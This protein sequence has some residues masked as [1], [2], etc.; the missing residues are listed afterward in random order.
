MPAM[1]ALPRLAPLP[2]GAALTACVPCSTSP[3]MAGATRHEITVAAD[4]SVATP[5]DLEAERVAVAFGGFASCLYVVD[6][7]VP[8]VRDALQMNARRSVPRMKRAVRG[9]WRAVP[10]VAE[11]CCRA[12]P[13]AA[14]AA[15]HLRSPEHVAI[16]AG[17]NPSLTTAVLQ[18]VL[19]AHARAGSFDLGLDEWA[20][21]RRCVL[22]P[23]GPVQLW[24]A[25]MHPRVVAAI[26]A[27]VVGDEGPALPEALY[28]G[29]LSR[30]PDLGWMADTL[31]AAASAVS[32]PISR[33]DTPHLAEWLAWSQTPLD[34]KQRQARTG[35]L[36]TGVPRG[37]IEQLSAAGYCPA[38]AQA[39]AAGTGR[40][41]AGV[42]DLL[43]SW[44][45][46]GCRPSVDDL[47]DLYGSGIPPWHSPSKRLVARLRSVVGDLAEHYTTTELGLMVVLEGTVAAA[48]AVIRAQA[49]P[50]RRRECA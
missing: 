30:R 22:G 32:A 44:V 20:V 26:H 6:T 15:G 39:L 4:W 41:V 48:A 33:Y 5:H 8:A 24:E 43:V 35:W 18:P 2:D 23:T 25:G 14:A 49:G 46:A 31:A 3:D 9:T 40:S 13:S 29:V 7:V 50:P 12:E 10:A 37:D 47:L 42:A 1:P 45:D 11:R 19:A 17:G 21:L 38:D 28:L 16:R 36:A 27:E 34:K